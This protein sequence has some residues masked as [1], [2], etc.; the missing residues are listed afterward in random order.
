MII[1]KS[2]CSHW[3]GSWAFCYHRPCH[4]LTLPLECTQYVFVLWRV[5]SHLI[6]ARCR[7][8][9]KLV[10]CQRCPIVPP[11][12]A[13]LLSPRDNTWGFDFEM[14]CR[15]LANPTP[16]WMG[17]MGQEWKWQSK[18]SHIPK[19]ARRASSWVSPRGKSNKNTR[20]IKV[21]TKLL[22][23]LATFWIEIKFLSRKRS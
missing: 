20:N 5:E 19:R 8:T 7:G 3:P 6:S 14:P 10:F 21:S 18:F 17:R 1:L 13:I 16:C 15:V 22:L 4:G 9:L 2:Q 12:A 23:R 11:S